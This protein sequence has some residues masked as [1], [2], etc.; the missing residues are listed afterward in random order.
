MAF[1]HPKFTNIKSQNTLQRS[2]AVHAYRDLTEVKSWHDVTVQSCEQ[3]V[4]L[5]A[6]EHAEDE[7]VCVVPTPA[8]DPLS[9]LKIDDLFKTLAQTTSQTERPQTFRL[10]LALVDTDT[11]VVYYNLYN[12]IQPPIEEPLSRKHR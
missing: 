8:Q 1:S 7:N 12:G 10:I 11:T 2:A 4:Y 5:L 6:R 9:P 3:L